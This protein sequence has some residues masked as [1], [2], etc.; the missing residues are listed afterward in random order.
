MVV[1]RG[2]G[3]FCAQILTLLTLHNGVRCVIV[4]DNGVRCVIVSDNGVR[5][6]IAK[7]PVVVAGLTTPVAFAAALKALLFRPSRCGLIGLD[8]GDEH[9]R[10]CTR[11]RHGPQDLSLDRHAISPWI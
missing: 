4:S 1:F 8:R 10:R 5:C 9:L 2:L 7:V 3:T 11:S 6:F